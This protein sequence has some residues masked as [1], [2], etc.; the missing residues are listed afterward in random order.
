MNVNLLDAL[1]EV[2]SAESLAAL[3]SMALLALSAKDRE[4]LL[5]GLIA[6]NDRLMSARE[7]LELMRD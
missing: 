7:Q 2:A 5:A 6:L 3:L 1:D 4:P